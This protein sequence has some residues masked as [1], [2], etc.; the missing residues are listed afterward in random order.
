VFNQFPVLVEN[1][2]CRSEIIRNVL[3]KTGV[4]MTTLYPEPLHRIYEMGYSTDPDPFP[5]ATRMARHLL[6]IPTHPLIKRATLTH[7]VRIIRS[8]VSV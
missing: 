2:D 5:N 1:S 3:S 7:V 4:E 6:L 8:V